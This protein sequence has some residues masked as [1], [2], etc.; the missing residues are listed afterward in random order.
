MAEAPGAFGFGAI[1][2]DDLDLF[3][4]IHSGGPTLG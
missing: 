2:V 3:S 1:E 4:V